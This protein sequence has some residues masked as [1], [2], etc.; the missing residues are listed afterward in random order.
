MEHQFLKTRKY[1]NFF[2]ILNRKSR[3]ERKRKGNVGVSDLHSLV[4][5]A[6]EDIKGKEILD[7]ADEI[8][9]DIYNKTK[10]KLEIEPN[11]I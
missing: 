11:L 8:M 6:Y 9:S 10:I 1:Q 7:F 2:C 3:L 4:L 5:V